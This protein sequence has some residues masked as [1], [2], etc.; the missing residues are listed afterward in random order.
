MVR[1]DHTVSTQ[2]TPLP[3]HVRLLTAYMMHIAKSHTE[4]D[5]KTRVK[6]L[7]LPCRRG[8]RMEAFLA[9]QD[10]EPVTSV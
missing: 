9:R 6:T 2:I 8:N 3:S 1:L 4:T 7:K 5:R 10:H